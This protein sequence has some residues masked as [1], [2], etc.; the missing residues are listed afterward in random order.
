MGQGGLMG[1]NVFRRR[2]PIEPGPRK[3]RM[4]ILS[5]FLALA[6]VGLIVRAWHLQ[7]KRHDHYVERSAGQHETTI[8]L[9]ASRGAI[10]DRN[11]RELALTA[12]VP[13][14]Y[15]DPRAVKNPGAAA[16][17][18]APLLDMD[19]TVLESRLGRAK[20]EFVWLKRHISPAIANQVMA[21]KLDGVALKDEP[22]RFYP[23]RGLAGPLIGFAGIDGIGLEGIERDYDRYLRGKEYTLEGLRDASGRKAM[24]GGSVLPEHLSG[25]DVQLTIDARIQ[26]LA[27]SALFEQ[28][29]AMRAA[30]G[31]VVVMD[32]KTGDV[33]AMAQ[34]PVFDPNLFRQAEPAQ[35]RNR[36]LTDVLEPG[37]TIKPLLI[38]SALDLGKVR[39]N[40]KWD[41]MHGR[42]RV[43]RK[44]ITDV[45]GVK[46]LTTLEIVQRSSNVGAV[47]VAQ[48]IG[49]QHFHQYLRAFG[50]GESTNVG[51]RGEQGGTLHSYKKWGQIHL[52]THAYGYN[53]SVT[54]LQM[55]RA[56]GVIANG[57][58]LM[59]P[60]LVKAV[61]DA[62]GKV[63]ESFPVRVVRKVLQPRAAKQATRAM[64]MV[65]QKG[66]TG[67][68]ARVPGYV[69]AGKTGT[70]NKVD[71]LV[72]GYSK[73]K[74]TSSFVGF[75]PA[76]DPRLVMYVVV[77]EPKEARYGGVVAGPI[78]SNIAR[79]A[80]PY[81]GVEATEPFEAEEFE[82][83][84]WDDMAEGL[85]PQA[86]PWWFEEAILAGA[87]AHMV[88]P[89]LRGAALSEVVQIAAGL[90]MNLAIEGAG[91]VTSQSPK[92]GA[93]L[94]PDATITITMA[95]PGT[96]PAKRAVQ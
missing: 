53:L 69:V 75:V 6:F 11:G 13:S 91:L 4:L 16:A 3:G 92:P 46:E 47:Q 59:R 72:G 45:H 43:G 8:T 29:K 32:P 23:N 9:R 84:E 80:L 81:L 31:V 96:P 88:V 51:L 89:D 95:L 20:K 10:R 7:V 73:T 82:G 77:D 93:L 65:T 38:A 78:F 28:V 42:I 87:P 14:V 63:V 57:G 67:R 48:R 37:S 35:W 2:E 66:G 15:T 24:P 19:K 71:P 27:E 17:A 79:E 90:K 68:R 55:V 60:R 70:A 64:I 25:Y 56:A 12:M 22:R 85:D 21:L 62:R 94:P 52:A 34:T 41:G 30:G 39:P 36:L 58:D 54:P 44:T 1:R 76:Q 50:F 5:V 40:Q 49:K 83:D 18:L 61:T 86:R 74:V 26:Q 33:L